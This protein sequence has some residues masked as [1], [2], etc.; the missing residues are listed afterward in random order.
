MLITTVRCR[1]EALVRA[2]ADGA[3]HAKFGQPWWKACTSA[4]A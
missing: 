4:C 2:V 1:C 3:P